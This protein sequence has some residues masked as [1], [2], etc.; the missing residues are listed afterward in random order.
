MYG[1]K[2]QDCIEMTE[3][4]LLKYW[5]YG[6]EYNIELR[7]GKIE[8]DVTKKKTQ[9]LTKEE[10]QQEKERLRKLYNYKG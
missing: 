6:W 8:K 10:L 4:E 3:S 9:D 1:F 5:Q 7:Y 2:Y